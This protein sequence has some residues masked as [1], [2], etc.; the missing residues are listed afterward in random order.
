MFRYWG[1]FFHACSILIMFLIVTRRS[2]IRGISRNTLDLYFVVY[3]LRY[4]DI[5]WNTYSMYNTAMKISYLLSSAMLCLVLRMPSIQAT[6][7][8]EYDVVQRRTIVLPSV[9]LGYAVVYMF[10]E[11]GIMQSRF[12]ITW[13]ISLFVESVA[14]IPQLYM[15]QNLKFADNITS[16]YVMCSG[17]YRVFYVIHW[18]LLYIRPQAKTKILPV[19][20]ICGVIQVLLYLDFFY[21]YVKTKK[22]GLN[23]PMKLNNSDKV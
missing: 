6:Y 14:I 5:F 21:H 18:C 22:M 12:E 2:N 13:T 10:N 19:A 9:L 7:D 11:P 20:W 1:D 3:V 16:H 23:K 8:R 15:I 4:W 17:L